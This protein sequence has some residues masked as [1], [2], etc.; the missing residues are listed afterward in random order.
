MIMKYATNKPMFFA[1]KLHQATKGAEMHQMTLITI[2]VSR[3]EINMN[4][5]KACYQKLYVISLCQDVPYET[6]RDYK[7]KC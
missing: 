1:E 5:I 2:M 6:K 7:K 3:S 4:D